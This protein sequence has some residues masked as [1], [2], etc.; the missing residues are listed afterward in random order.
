MNPDIQIDSTIIDE[1]RLVKEFFKNCEEGLLHNLKRDLDNCFSSPKLDTAARISIKKAATYRSIYSE[2]LNLLLVY[3]D[4]NYRNPNFENSNILM[5]ACAEGNFFIIEQISN[6]DFSQNTF[7]P[8]QKLNLNLK[9]NN[10][11]NFLHHLLASQ[12]QEDD[13]F[14]IISR[15]VSDNDYKTRYINQDDNLYYNQSYLN[16]NQTKKYNFQINVKDVFNSSDIF[17]N[18][19]LSIT[20]CKGWFKLSK[21]ILMIAE[22]RYLNKI[23]LNNYIH[24]AVIGK[25]LNCLN[26]ILKESSLE[27][28]RQ[29]NRD[30][31]AP[32]DIAKKIEMFYFSRIIENFEENCHN[33][34]YFN[35]FSDRSIIS[36]DKIFDKFIQE[37]YSESLFLLGQLNTVK[38]IREQINY[39]LEWN[40]LLNKLYMNIEK[41][42]QDKIRK[43]SFKIYPENILSKFL[44]NKDRNYNRKY[45][46]KSFLKMM[47]EFFNS[48]NPKNNQNNNNYN[49]DV[50]DVLIMN[51]GLFY[52]KIGDDDESIKVFWDYYK[53]YLEYKHT[54]FYK[55][56]IY[57]NITF[58]IIEIFIRKK[59]F[60]LVNLAI[61]KLEEFLFT[62]FHEKKDYTLDDHILLTAGYLDSKEIINNYTD[63]WDES[64]CLLNLYKAMKFLSENKLK[65]TKICFKEYKK[66]NKNC[67]YKTVIP[68]FETLNNF[69]VSLKIKLFYSEDNLEKCFKNLNKI[70]QITKNENINLIINDR[71]FNKKYEMDAY[72]IFYLNTMGIMYLKKKKYSSAEYF[73]KNCIEHFKNIWVKIQKSEFNISIRLHD[74]FLIKY[75]LALCYF[76]QKKFEEAYKIFKEIVNKKNITNHVFIW[77]RMGICLLEIEL[78]KLRKIRETNSISDYISNLYGYSVESDYCAKNKNGNISDS[79]LQSHLNKLKYNNTK[80]ISNIN[81]S[82]PQFIKNNFISLNNSYR[83]KEE[84][85]DTIKYLN[86]NLKDTVGISNLDEKVESVVNHVNKMNEEIAY[87]ELINRNHRRII[88]QNNIIKENKDRNNTISRKKMLNS[89]H[90]QTQIDEEGKEKN[91]LDFNDKSE[92]NII[93]INQSLKLNEILYCLRK[94]IEF[95][96]KPKKNSQEFE[97]LYIE[98]EEIINFFSNK[99]N[100]KNSTSSMNSPSQLLDDNEKNGLINLR[101]ISCFSKSYNFL[102]KNTYLTLIFTLIL[103]KNWFNAL[104]ILREFEQLDFIKNDHDLNIILNNYLIEIYINLNQTEKALEI[105]ENQINSSNNVEEKMQFYSFTNNKIYNEINFRLILYNNLMKLHVMNDNFQEAEKCLTNLLKSLNFKNLNEIPFFIINHIIYLNLLKGNTDIIVNLIKFR[106]LNINNVIP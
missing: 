25:N 43:D 73:F 52:F 83:E 44:E 53:Y 30:G 104:I 48:V 8:D 88:L 16:F 81:S 60:L 97:S 22:E 27:D 67:N 54:R 41:G 23:D 1:S 47:S 46:N 15:F 21:Y 71:K 45:N 89:N 26:L 4:V 37:N 102:L 96:K 5:F 87:N 57:V 66:L 31:Y 11:R 39:S 84:N 106:R 74:I 82:N 93:N 78:I 86:E 62:R 98:Y 12:I 35:V 90:L 85:W 59:L 61:N 49:N 40:I 38:S 91:G 100:D 80:N 50:L 36:P 77:Y 7:K 94:V 92:I 103:D 42:T 105:L 64:F 17:G 19:P 28:V 70:Y 13:A 33:S 63:T 6:F 32:A 51:K 14:E 10:Q 95:F 72:I 76:Y 55:W 68:I 34:N 75:N 69:Y 9:D 2:C 101:N 3:V 79:N 18:T 99:D 20:L 65:D 24:Y 58:I 56:I 29:K